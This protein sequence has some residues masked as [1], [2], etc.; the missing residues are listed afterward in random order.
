M[1]TVQRY[2]IVSCTER[3]TLQDEVNQ[4]LEMGWQVQGGVAIFQ[5]GNYPRFYQAMVRDEEVLEEWD[6]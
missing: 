4:Y 2:K 1:N 6:K 3:E 5:L